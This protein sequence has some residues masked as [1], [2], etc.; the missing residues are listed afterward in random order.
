MGDNG[1]MY[2]PEALLPVYREKV[3][4]VSDIITPNHFEAE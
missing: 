2:V 3:V 4:R 1:S